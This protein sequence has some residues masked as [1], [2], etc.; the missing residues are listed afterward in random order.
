MTLALDASTY[1]VEQWVLFCLLWGTLLAA[2][3]IGVR[4]GLSE[5]NKGLNRR[6]PL[7]NTASSAALALLGLLLGFTF[8]MA[9]SRFDARREWVLQE[10]N[11]IGT[12][13]LR[14]QLL[15]KPQSETTAALFR[16]YVDNRLDLYSSGDPVYRATELRKGDELRSR[17]WAETMAAANG[18]PVSLYTSLAI[19][20]LNAVIDSDAG[21]LDA[22]RNRLPISATLLLVFA[23]V[24]CL[25]MLGWQSALSGTRSFI[26]TAALSLLFALVITV[27]IDLDRPERGLIRASQWPMIELQ[28]SIGPNAAR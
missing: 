21:R 23:A 9:V 25:A 7:I 22:D 13:Y 24:L 5:F 6:Y 28:K 20:A 10:S 14:T 12:A 4:L 19:Q 3:E 27:I 26:T 17:L 2:A 8:S 18:N 11:A 15:P 1:H 16:Q